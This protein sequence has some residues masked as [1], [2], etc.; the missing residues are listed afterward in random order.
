MGNDDFNIYNGY[1]GQGGGEVSIISGEHT[2]EVDK[3]LVKIDDEVVRVF[4][5]VPFHVDYNLYLFAQ[6]RQGY[7]YAPSQTIV[8]S[9]CQIY[10]NGALIRDFIPYIEGDVVGL[11]DLVNDQFYMPIDGQ[12]EAVIQ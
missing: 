5:Y 7:A 10:D 3:N 12:L 4:D 8:M 1:D 6:N 11:Y 2:I 9:S